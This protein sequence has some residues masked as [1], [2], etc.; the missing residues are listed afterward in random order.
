MV[1]IYIWEHIPTGVPVDR[2][3]FQNIILIFTLGPVKSLEL[4]PKTLIKINYFEEVFAFII[5]GTYYYLITCFI[6][7]IFRGLKN[8][9]KK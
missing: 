4:F 5:L 7:A 8:R 1:G 9:F 2:S 6:F 3:L